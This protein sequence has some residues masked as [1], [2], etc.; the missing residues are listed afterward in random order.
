MKPDTIYRVYAII[1]RPRGWRI[2]ERKSRHGNDG[3]ACIN[4][5][6]LF[7]PPLVDPYAFYVL[8]HEIGHV[9]LKHKLE[10]GRTPPEELPLEWIE[11]YEAETFA[12]GIC[13][14]EGIRVARDTLQAAREYVGNCFLK[15]HDPSDLD[16]PHFRKAL[17]FA[18][19]KTWREHL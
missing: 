4:R 12:I 11:E 3:M 16:H 15:H 1:H 18:F 8:M 7:C 2:R 6:T 10:P 17:R 13:R 9:V 5:K 14:Q 19:P